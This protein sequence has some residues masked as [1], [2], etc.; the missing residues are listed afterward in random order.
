VT[1][2]EADAG[3]LA[4]ARERARQDDVGNVTCVP[5]HL[6]DDVVARD[7]RF[8]LVV[9]GDECPEART[10]VPF[11]DTR[12]MDRLAALVDEGGC[13]LYGV[14]SRRSDALRGR[15]GALSSRGI[16]AS[17]PAHVR[18]LRRRFATVA[19]YW[20]SPARRPY[21]VYAPLDESA[22]LPYWID[23]LPAPSGRRAH[24]LHHALH[25]A[26]RIRGLG[27]VVDNFVLVAQRS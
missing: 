6:L 27:L 24:V 3:R 22:A 19:A 8:D 7:G 5:A 2:A 25:V 16:P 17:F 11:S 12:T 1:V 21:H 18:H 15:L 23:H 20:R 10:S 4:F 14:R 9:L 13:L 26:T